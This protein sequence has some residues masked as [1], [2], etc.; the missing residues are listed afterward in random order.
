[1]LA[2]LVAPG[3]SKLRCFLR[4]HDANLADVGTTQ[5]A[6]QSPERENL[7][8]SQTRASTGSTTNTKSLSASIVKRPT[9]T[10]TRS[11]MPKM[12]IERSGRSARRRS[13]EPSISEDSRRD[14][15]P[16]GFGR[17]EFP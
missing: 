13:S 1:M 4:L 15:Q 3:Y 2:G 5:L 14:I 7:R 16:Y 10:S 6:G 9:A 12:A 11:G 17:S 8:K